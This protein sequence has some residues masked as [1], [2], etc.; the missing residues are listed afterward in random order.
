[1]KSV[2]N[3]SENNASRYV[4]IEYSKLQEDTATDNLIVEKAAIS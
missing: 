4:I 3:D 1:M 2:L